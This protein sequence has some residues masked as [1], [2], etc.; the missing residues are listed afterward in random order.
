MIAETATGD[1]EFYSATYRLWNLPQLEPHCEDYGQVVIYKGT[2]PRHPSG[3]FLDKHH[4]FVTGNAMLVC[5]NTWNMLKETTLAPHFEFIGNFKTHYGIFEGCGSSI[6]YESGS[7]SKGEYQSSFNWLNLRY[8][9]SE[10][11]ARALISLWTTF[12]GK[13]KIL[14]RLAPSSSLSKHCGTKNTVSNDIPKD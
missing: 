6:P 2:L 7:E 5:G 12:P 14:G 10:Q 13:I 9:G 8:Q 1:L 4:Y 3:S 11:D